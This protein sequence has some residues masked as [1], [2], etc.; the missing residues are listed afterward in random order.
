MTKEAE[1]CTLKQETISILNLGPPIGSW[2]ATQIAES[3]CRKLQMK[4]KKRS[5]LKIIGF[6]IAGLCIL[7]V[8]GIVGL[9]VFSQ[10]IYKAMLAGSSLQVGTAAPDFQLQTLSGETVRLS[11]YRGQPVLLTIGAA[12]CTD[13]QRE[14]P[15]LQELHAKHPEL[16]IMMVDVKEDQAIVNRF[17]DQYGL[18]F[19]IA[20]DTDGKVND[21][22]RVLA[23]PTE[24]FI[25]AQGIIRARII[26]QVTAQTL[27][28]MLE[29]VGIQ[30]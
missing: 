23:I 25:D 8:L 13:C 17:A 28:A 2:A 1:I 20:L 9:T 11:Q 29:Q 14:A 6:T 5:V 27:P 19:T 16:S 3:E 18:T 12:W 7:A 10:K 4:T 21:Q 24:L 15:L 30:P 22:Y 26:E